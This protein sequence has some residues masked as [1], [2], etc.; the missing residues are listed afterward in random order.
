MIKILRILWG[1]LCIVVTICFLL[2]SLSTF[3]P[4]SYFSYPSLFGLGFPYIFVI[5]LLCCVIGLF[6]NR[7]YALIRICL[8]PVSY[9]N[10]TNTFALR[11]EQQWVMEKDTSTLRVMTWNV[12]G[13]VN[14]LRKESLSEYRDS[15][16]GIIRN[17][18]N[19]N[20]D[21]ICIQEYR[22][23]ENA[24]RRYPIRKELDSIGFK[25]YYCSNDRVTRLLK[26]SD[27]TLTEGVAIYSKLP[28]IDSGRININHDDKNENLIYTDVM[29]N[30]KRVRVFTAHLQSLYIYTDTAGKFQ[31]ESIYEITYKEK[32]HAEYRIRETEIKHEEEVKI[33][34]AAIDASNYPVIYCGDMNTTPGS[35]NYRLLKDDNLQDAFLAKGS[36]LGNT[37][38]KIGPTLR[39]DYCLPDTAFRVI[40]SKREK[41]KLSDHFP[42][43]AD[44]QWK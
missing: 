9:F 21:I 31:D 33:I 29:F 43:I 6:I 26:N 30:N 27:A 38:Y 44:I 36:G 4:P 22:N 8:L 15:R 32:R 12:Q 2:A 7:R 10:F 20:P 41:I 11:T 23:I 39:I 40:Q 28:L 19:Y 24:K 42:V 18:N 3:I 35:Y 37:F 13:F 34:R 17:I 16:E 25:Y 14:N 1:A 5:Y